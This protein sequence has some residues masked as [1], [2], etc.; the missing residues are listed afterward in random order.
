[1]LSFRKSLR[2]LSRLPRFLG[3]TTQTWGS[4]IDGEVPHSADF[5]A[6][7]ENMDRLVA[8]LQETLTKVHDGG[9]EK[10]KQRLKAR[11]KLLARERID[12]LVDPGSP[13]LEVGTLAGLGMYG[14]WVPSG[15]IITGIG[16]VNGYDELSCN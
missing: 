8:N 6:N 12:R 7:K 10:A 9:G 14:D 11:N 3:T 2:P 16:R 1:M 4:L 5:V 15:G 13:F